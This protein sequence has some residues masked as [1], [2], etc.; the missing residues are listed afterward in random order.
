MS[1][2]DLVPTWF[3]GIVAGV[4]MTLGTIELS[5]GRMVV[6]PRRLKWSV[7]EVRVYGFIS[8]LF[9]LIVAIYVLVNAIVLSTGP[10]Q[11]WVGPGWWYDLDWLMYALGIVVATSL[12][13][14]E[15][16]H[17]KQWPFNRPRLDMRTGG[18][19]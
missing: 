10:R 1:G 9:G 18:Q 7:G 16:H 17:N 2:I 4:V 8:A 5:T 6:N 3:G 14:V 19:Q 15:Q 12:L 13:L 11:N